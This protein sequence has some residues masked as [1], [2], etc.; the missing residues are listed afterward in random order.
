MKRVIVIIAATVAIVASSAICL[1]GPPRDIRSPDMKIRL[2]AND[3][4]GFVIHEDAFF[5]AKFVVMDYPECLVNYAE[6][7]QLAVEVAR[8]V[9][10]YFGSTNDIRVVH[11]E[12]AH[13][14][15]TNRADYILGWLH[16]KWVTDEVVPL[17]SKGV[18][19]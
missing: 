1:S 7:R 2:E 5:G 3:K 10:N 17:R 14:A 9:A 16:G 4:H 19:K 15:S 11:W 18:V 13:P 12:E 6:H 8:T